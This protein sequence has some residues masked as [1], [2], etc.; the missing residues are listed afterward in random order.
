MDSKE[1]LVGFFAAILCGGGAIALSF[2]V[3]LR[4]FWWCPAGGCSLVPF[5]SK[6]AALA[7]VLGV[8]ALMGAFS[9]LLL[10][11]FAALVRPF[12][13]RATMERVV[14]SAG[15]PGLAWYDKLQRKWVA[16]L[17]R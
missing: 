17:Y 13:S 4:T 15:L 10:F 11:P 5:A 7:N 12:V 3:A 1:R 16:L 6:L 2:G 9:L 8:I 14:L